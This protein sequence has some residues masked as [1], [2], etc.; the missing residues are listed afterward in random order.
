MAVDRNET[1]V[2]DEMFIRL[3]VAAVQGSG[4]LTP[5]QVVALA[6]M[7]QQ[8]TRVYFETIYETVH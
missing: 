4:E 6:T 5:N 3:V 1:D 2:M 7:A 8:Y